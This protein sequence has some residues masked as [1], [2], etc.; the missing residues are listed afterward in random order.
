M[1]IG[2]QSPPSGIGDGVEGRRSVFLMRHLLG[3]VVV[4]SLG[5]GSAPTTMIVPL[6][7][8]P[9]PTVVT[10]A[11]A[12]GTPLPKTA[13]TSTAAVTAL[14]RLGD[15]AAAL[16]DG[17]LVFADPQSAALT[18]VPVGASGEAMSL[19][20]IRTVTPRGTGVW[21]L[22]SEGLFHSADGRLLRSPLS[23]S[24][25][26]STVADVL[27]FGSGADEALWVRM[28]SGSL[29]QLKNGKKTEVSFSLNG[30]VVTGAQWLVPAGADRALVATSAKELFRVD[31]AA[32]SVK[33]IAVSLPTVTLSAT[34]ADGTVHLA[35]QAGLFTVKPDD[36]VTQ[37]TFAA[38]GATP[39]P[40]T[41][42]ESVEGQL[43]AVVGSKLL[44][45][46]NGAFVAV[47]TLTAAAPRAVTQVANGDVLAIDSQALF[48][49]KAPA[50]TGPSFATDVK[51]FIVAECQQACHSNG[52][53]YAPIRRYDDYTTA[54]ANAALLVKRV[55]ADGTSPMPPASYKVLSASQYAPLV[56]WAQGAQ[57]P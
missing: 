45:R 52:A 2:Y 38:E 14:F 41:D 53:N 24:L 23:D 32:S 26:V 56:Q 8:P 37:T 57:L 16:R 21:V 1:R 39:L 11:P 27:S 13:A 20:S 7:A 6:E 44:K 50:Q 19:T 5:C 54:R 43:Y 42:V 47:Q 12:E 31:L 10:G 49:L 28:T 30:A 55:T 15:T 46:V 48:A 17:T 51:P 9:A 3:S 34:E 4:L 40:V 18:P 35:T 25:D 33:R 36:S 29:A 22:A